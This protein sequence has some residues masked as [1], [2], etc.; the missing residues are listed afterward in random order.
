METHLGL[1][2][3]CSVKHRRYLSG[4]LSTV[5]MTLSRSA[6]D[7]CVDI[8]IST[9]TGHRW[10]CVALNS[11]ETVTGNDASQVFRAARQANCVIG[12]YGMDM[13]VD[14]LEQKAKRL[15][16]GELS[17]SVPWGFSRVHEAC[18]IVICF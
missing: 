10:G 7:Y 14:L 3:V 6:G 2:T 16:T 1:R 8:L 17:K 4:D 9:P 18:Y 15:L 13:L 5:T 12:N 11:T